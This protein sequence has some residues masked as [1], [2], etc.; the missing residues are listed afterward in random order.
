MVK[1]NDG[2]QA[3]AQQTQQKK[4]TNLST[5]TADAAKE[6]DKLRHRHIGRSRRSGQTQVLAQRT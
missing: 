6:A 4:R 1:A 2:T 5:G 3:Q